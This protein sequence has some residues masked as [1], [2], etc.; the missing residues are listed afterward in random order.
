M[1]RFDLCLVSRRVAMPDG[2][3]PAAILVDEGRISAIVDPAEAP[4]DALDVGDLAVLP[5]LVDS[6]VHINEPGRTAWEG[7]TSATRAAAAGGITTLVDMPLN[8]LPPTTTPDALAVK[9][10]VA[11]DKVHVDVGF[12]GGVVPGSE[13][14]LAD[15]H[16]QG[17]LGFKAFLCDSGVE[18]YG[19]FPPESTGDIV[20]GTAMLGATLIVHAEHP[21]VVTGATRA[22]AD[23]GADP[24]RYRTWLEGRPAAAEVEAVDAMLEAARASGAR[25]HILHL[26]A[27]EAGE[28]CAAA[29]AEGVAVTVETCPHYLTLA[30]ERIPD[31]STQHKCAP[32]IRDQANADRLWQL[33]DDGVIDAIVSDHSPCP[34]ELKHLDTGDF[35]QAW[36]G[37]ASVQLGLSLVWTEARRRGHDLDDIARWMA[38]GPA[39]IAGLTHKGA[40]EVGNDADLVVFDPDTTWRVDGGALEHRHPITPYDGREVAG[41]VR[42]TYLRGT[43]VARDGRPV[44]EP[45]GALL[46]RGAA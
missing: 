29:R 39:H 3:R 26:S 12:W 42:A 40:I 28:R 46:V 15:L 44:G 22:V 35:T 10:A 43:A 19:H 18:E 6:H 32:P 45:T 24:T 16:A 11:Q 14:H 34:P 27:A 7:F 20:V 41:I 9:R 17:V 33:L 30:A 5:G 36:G 37:I 4:P 21:D 13:Q 23:S 31:G 38:A 2:T 8:C 25:I 1:D